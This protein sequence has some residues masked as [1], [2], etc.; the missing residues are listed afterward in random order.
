MGHETKSLR[1]AL[2]RQELALH[3]QPMVNLRNNTVFGVE[4]LLRW[5]Q[6]EST[7]ASLSPAAIFALAKE[8][9]LRA[10]LGAWLLQTA[11]Q[12]AQTWQDQGLGPLTMSVNLTAEYF[13]Q[14][15]LLEQIRHTLSATGLAPQHLMLEITE[16]AL[17]DN[18]D[19]NQACE[20]LA[21]LKA[22]GVQLTLDDYGSGHSA[23]SDLRQLPLNGLKLDRAFLASLTT[24]PND[25]AI[26]A[27]VI[28]LAHSL[29]LVMGCVGIESE[30]QLVFIREQRCDIA[31][32][33]YFSPALTADKVPTWI[34][35]FQQQSLPSATAARTVLVLDDDASI[36]AWLGVI[37]KRDG[38]TV[39]TARTAEQALGE[40]A[41]HPVDVLIADYSLP[42]MS[43][44][45]FLRRVRSIYPNTVRIMFSGQADQAVV[46]DAINEGGVFQ[47]LEKSVN[48]E[49]ILSAVHDAFALRESITKLHG[50]Q[51][52]N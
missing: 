10:S 38:Y 12:Q 43:G 21:V 47:F 41:Q 7:Q 52:Q 30:S 1:A 28:S 22:L 2:Q 20:V 4:A 3:Y 17:L 49:R 37:L 50:G 27:A 40:L 15:D 25:A 46:T 8:A 51:Y 5:P 34:G 18:N 23:L 26:V 11:C 48:Q 36:A 24:N 42:G 14:T 19:V 33:Y 35:E 29:G 32:G 6:A 9:D 44:V 16:S 45:K 39:I 13:W 31:Q